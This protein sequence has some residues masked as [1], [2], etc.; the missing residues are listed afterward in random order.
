MNILELIKKQIDSID[1]NNTNKDALISTLKQC[2]DVI[3]K[4]E[5]EIPL[6]ESLKIKAKAL[7]AEIKKTREENS[8]LKSKNE[9][10]EDNIK[11]L[12]EIFESTKA[13]ALGQIKLLNI[14]K[15][16]YKRISNKIDK[17]ENINEILNLIS[18]IKIKT[19]RHFGIEKE[20][21]PEIPKIN[22]HLSKS[23]D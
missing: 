1:H 4:L 23:G 11:K 21:I 22:P 18:I 2:K 5:Q 3:S 15:E 20:K 14:S 17:S 16:D 7:E 10:A 9:A 13:K 6:S 19:K 12:N 8:R